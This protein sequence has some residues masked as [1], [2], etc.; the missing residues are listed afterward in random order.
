MVVVPSLGT[1]GGEK[2]AIDIASHIDRKQIEV[3][4]VSLYGKK[5]TVLDRYA[6]SLGLNIVYLDKKLGFDYR[7]IGRLRKIYEMFKPNVVHTHLYVVPYVLLSTP[8]HIKKFHT[9]HNLAEKE[10]TGLLR[11]I[12]RFAY[13]FWNFNPVAISPLCANSLSK[14]YKIPFDKIPCILNGINVKQFDLAK[15]EHSKVRFLNVGRFYPQK[16]QKLLIDAFA[17]VHTIVPETEL[18]IVGD[19]YLRDELEIQVQQLNLTNAVI[20]KGE[21][22]K[23]AC[24]LCSADVYVM[25]SDFEGLPVSV[26]EAMA[27]GLPIVST[28]AGGTVD[29]VTNGVNGLIVDV[30]NASQLAEAMLNLANDKNLRITMGQKSKERAQYYSIEK[31]S[32]EYQRLYIGI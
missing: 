10:A 21:S 30:G 18:E 4:I 32:E 24:K 2:I 17:K 8:R 23:I 22:D 3:L 16:N 1:G 26:L 7:V 20:M 19:G 25:S 6:N 31:C 14:L 11:I 5:E 12:M 27:S 15:K 28:A 9:V 29:I 13:K